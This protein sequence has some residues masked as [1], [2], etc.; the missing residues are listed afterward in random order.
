MELLLGRYKYINELNWSE[1][2]LFLDVMIKCHVYNMDTSTGG[3]DTSNHPSGL[4]NDNP[5]I[6]ELLVVVN[7]ILKEQGFSLNTKC[8]LGIYWGN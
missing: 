6:K 2:N 4:I 1:L 8:K 3:Y 7:Q 5:V